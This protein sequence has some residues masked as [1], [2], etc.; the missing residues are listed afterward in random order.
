MTILEMTEMDEVKTGFKFIT[1]E[2][3][4]PGVQILSVNGRSKLDKIKKSF[5]NMPIVIGKAEKGDKYVPMNLAEMDHKRNN[6]IDAATTSVMGE[7]VDKLD[8]P[9]KLPTNLIMLVFGIMIGVASTY[10]AYNSF[11]IN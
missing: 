8:K 11:I 10:Y 2:N 6:I 3:A 4:L 7:R 1:E 9:V 5:P